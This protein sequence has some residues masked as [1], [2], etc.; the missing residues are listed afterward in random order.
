MEQV[1][2]EYMLLLLPSSA[3]PFRQALFFIK[4]RAGEQLTGTLVDGTDSVGA[5]FAWLQD[6]AHLTLSNVRLITKVPQGV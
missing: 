2:L 3:Q 6:G 1:A 4:V 5:Y